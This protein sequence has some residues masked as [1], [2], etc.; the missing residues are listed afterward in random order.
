MA[1]KTVI[2]SRRNLR[3]GRAINKKKDKYYH[4]S[5]K[6]FD[7]IKIEDSGDLPVI[8]YKNIPEGEIEC[9]YIKPRKDPQSFG[10][11]MNRKKK[12]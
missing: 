1:L 4:H 8:S 10:K 6:L 7:Q 3:N 11:F 2:V 5:N 9:D 12:S